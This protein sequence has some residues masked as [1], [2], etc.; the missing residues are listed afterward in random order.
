MTSSSCLQSQYHMDDTAKFNSQLGVDPGP[1]R[2]YLQQLFYIKAML[3]WNRKSLILS[4]FTSW[5]LSRQWDLTLRASFLVQSRRSLFNSIKLLNNYILSF[6][7]VFGC[8]LSFLVFFFSLNCTFLY[9][10]LPHPLF[11]CRSV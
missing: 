8:K 3:S 7:T 6:S 4:P 5:T 9:F 2:S 11:H 1:L 10:F